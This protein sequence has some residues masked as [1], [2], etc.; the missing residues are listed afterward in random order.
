MKLRA[1]AFVLPV[2]MV[3][4]SACGGGGGGTAAG[5]GGNAAKGKDL[6]TSKQC[7]TCHTLAGV[8]GAV[9]TIG[10]PLNGIG[11]T[12]ASRKS[13]MTADAYIR[14]SI[15]TPDAFIVDGF[16]KPSLMILPVA[17]TDAEITDLA[18]FL[19]SQK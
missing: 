15:K 4:L 10:P 17:V 9:G 18:A 6:F 3:A 12:A 19:V 11:S 2:L 14:E 8:T 5:G 16:T 7:I 13:G 1:L